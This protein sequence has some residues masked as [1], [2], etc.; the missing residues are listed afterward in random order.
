[1][2]LRTASNRRSLFGRRLRAGRPLQLDAEWLALGPGD[3]V[4]GAAPTSPSGRVSSSCGSAG[5]Q[6]LMLSDDGTVLTDPDV[7]TTRE[8]MDA[9][10]ELFKEEG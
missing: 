3:L 7:L 6:L 1:L 9:H 10:P 4:A 2:T 8:F 5:A